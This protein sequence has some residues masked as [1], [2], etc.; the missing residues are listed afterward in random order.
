MSQ[1]GR[2]SQTNA[3]GEGA[4]PGEQSCRLRLD[5]SKGGQLKSRFSP[6]HPTNNLTRKDAPPLAF[7]QIISYFWNIFSFTDFYSS[8]Y[9][10]PEE[11]DL[12]QQQPI[13]A[14]APPPQSQLSCDTPHNIFC[15]SR[16]R[17]WIY[18]DFSVNLH[19]RIKAEVRGVMNYFT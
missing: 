18:F 8:I 14:G 17:D 13:W 5:D 15:L 16:Q 11:V 6:F 7:V 19:P 12:E 3:Q 1:P 2:G 4:L 9:I 10:E